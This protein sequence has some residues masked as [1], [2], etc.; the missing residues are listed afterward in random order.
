[1][2]LHLLNQAQVYYILKCGSDSEES[3]CNAGDPGWMPESGRS[4]GE[5]NGNPL[6][7]SFLG[8]P[9]DRGA[10]LATVLELELD[11]TEQLNNRLLAKVMFD[12]HSQ[13]KNQSKMPVSTTHTHTHIYI[14]PFNFA[15]SRYSVYL[16]KPEA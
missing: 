14:L 13:Q 7:Y 12:N 2:S 8:N 15:E 4:P 5:G 16:K 10:W 1:M 3:A 6:Q 9:T 11:M